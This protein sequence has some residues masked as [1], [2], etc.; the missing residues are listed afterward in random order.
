MPSSSG[1]K[2]LSILKTKTVNTPE[3][4]NND[5]NQE[6][7]RFQP[8]MVEKIKCD[9]LWENQASWKLRWVVFQHNAFG[10]VEMHSKTLLMHSEMFAMV[11]NGN[12]KR[13]TPLQNHFKTFRKR[14][15][16]LISIIISVNDDWLS[17]VEFGRVLLQ[18]SRITGSRAL[19]IKLIIPRKRKGLCSMFTSLPKIGTLFSNYHCWKKQH[20]S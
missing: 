10:N 16:T 7:L 1:I 5:Y 11:P 17:R 8:K 18:L 12:R 15:Q 13:S 2:L 20:D 6:L 19:F 4:S 9:P 3:K 14:L